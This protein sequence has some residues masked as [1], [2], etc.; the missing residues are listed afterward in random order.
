MKRGDLKKLCL[1]LNNLGVHT[2]HLSVQ[3]TL[4]ALPFFNG[5]SDK[6][7]LQGLFHWILW[8]GGG[9]KMKWVF[10]NQLKIKLL[11]K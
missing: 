11:E 7:Y 10:A 8:K 9:D 5:P 4:R 2:I 3:V 6:I 1:K